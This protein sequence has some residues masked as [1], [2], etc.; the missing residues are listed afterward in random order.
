MADMR[1]VLGAYRWELEFGYIYI[2]F[3]F[4]LIFLEPMVSL[5][6]CM[7]FFVNRV[8]FRCFNHNA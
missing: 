1:N 5:K 6:Y 3:F 4:E 2:F 7:F 8:F